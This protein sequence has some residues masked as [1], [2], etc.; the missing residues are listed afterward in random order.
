MTIAI[1]VAVDQQNGIGKQNDLLCHLPNDLKRF[2]ELTLNHSVIMGRKTYLSLPKR[3]L[4]GR[5]NIVL[6]AQ[7]GNLDGECVVVSS[8]ESAFEAVKGEEE[9][10]VMGGASV[11][12]Q[13]LPQADKIYLTRIHHSFAE[14]DVFFPA[15]D[16]DQWQLVAKEEHRAD[17]RHCYDYTFETY[18]RK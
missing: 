16:L 9:V 18:I 10:F 11:Y 1:I 5:K 13:A 15:V 3:P 4:P 7:K 8:L 6:T 14:A 17:E 12:E 2:K